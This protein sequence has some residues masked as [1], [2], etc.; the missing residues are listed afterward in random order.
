M[1]ISY[2]LLIVQTEFI[3]VN[4]RAITFKVSFAF[5]DVILISSIN[6]SQ[7]KRLFTPVAY[8]VYSTRGTTE[9]IYRSRDRNKLASRKYWL[10]F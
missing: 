7:V 8:M 3:F 1:N 5:V 6:C 2:L 9:N 4:N 10:N